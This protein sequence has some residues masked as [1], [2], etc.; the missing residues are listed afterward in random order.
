MFILNV[1]NKTISWQKNEE[2]IY[3]ILLEGKKIP[4]EYKD[5]FLIG[6]YVPCRELHIEP[7]WLLIYYIDKQE[8]IIYFI[9]LGSHSNLFDG[10]YKLP[11][12]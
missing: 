9:R 12:F 3:D 7:D 10:S 2:E 6:N 1:L 4:L 8:Q 11:K 5:H